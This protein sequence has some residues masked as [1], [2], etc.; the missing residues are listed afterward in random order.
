[1]VNKYY[2]LSRFKPKGFPVRHRHKDV[3]D[4]RITI[5]PEFSSRVRKIR[6]LDVEFNRFILRADD[7]FDLI[8]DAYASN[9]HWSTSLEGNPLSED[10][11]RIVTRETLSGMGRERKGGPSQEVVNHLVKVYAPNA[12]ELPWT[13]RTICRLNEFLLSDTGNTARIGEYRESRVMVGDVITG[14]EHFIPAPPEYISDYM[15]RLLEWTNGQAAAYEP[16]AAATVMFHE[17]ESIHPFE[18][19]NGR[20]GRCLFHLYLQHRALNNSHL[21]MIDRKIL[22]DQDLYYDLLGYADETGSYKELIDLISIAI[23]E[24]YEEAFQTLSRK[25]LLGS[26]I[27]ETSKRLLIKARAHKEYFSLAEAKEWIDLV[28]EQT[29]RKRLN[30]LEELGALESI[31]RTRSK[32]YRMKDPLL[33]YKERIL[34]PGSMATPNNGVS[35]SDR[36]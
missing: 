13:D 10:E 2:N 15:A 30:E 25:D 8:A 23:L 35:S 27:D 22:E 24:S 9:I 28:G 3:F 36:R 26:G 7:Y 20:T 17:F 16:I 18:D 34:H 5:S 29:I 1:M 4:P 33:K 32:R 12:F 14:E 21:C 11:V 6:E 19:G 31:G